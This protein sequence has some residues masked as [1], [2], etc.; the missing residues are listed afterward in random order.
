MQGHM[1]PGDDADDHSQR[2][3]QIRS[4]GVRMENLIPAA[5][6]SR[7]HRPCRGSATATQSSAEGLVHA[8]TLSQAFEEPMSGTAKRSPVWGTGLGPRQLWGKRYVEGS[9]AA[10]PWMASHPNSM[11]ARPEG[12]SQLARLSP[13]C[14]ASGDSLHDRQVATWGRQVRACWAGRED[15]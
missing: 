5:G 10:H 8:A 9:S 3:Y 7:S 2:A 11:R 13:R 14:S 15:R 12:R 1:R 6:R 4:E